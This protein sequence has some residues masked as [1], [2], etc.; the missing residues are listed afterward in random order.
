[1]TTTGT[2]VGVAVAVGVATYTFRALGPWLGERVHLPEQVEQLMADAAVV[3]LTALVVTA[4]VFDGH[5][6]AGPSR[7]I[8]VGVGALLAWRRASFVLV[9]LAAA[10]TTAVLRL[11]GM[12]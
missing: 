10:G 2:L 5:A 9:V 4:T 6:F 12:P 8:G 3:L 11:L 7:L 1:M